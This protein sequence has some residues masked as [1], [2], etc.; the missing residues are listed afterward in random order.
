MRGIAQ[1]DARE[2]APVALGVL[3][4]DGL[5]LLAG[6]ELTEPAEESLQT[7]SGRVALTPISRFS[8]TRPP[9][10]AGGSSQSAMRKVRKSTTL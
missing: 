4:G 2:Q 1:D 8:K 5:G 10:R 9:Q 3:R 7:A 6:K